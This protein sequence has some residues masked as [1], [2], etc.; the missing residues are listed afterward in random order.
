MNLY[1][2]EIYAKKSKGLLVKAAE[3]GASS[4][5]NLLL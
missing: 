4:E 3:I 5:F 2:G 1:M